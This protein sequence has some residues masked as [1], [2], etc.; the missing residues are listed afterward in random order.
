MCLFN[1]TMR[2]S[3]HNIIIDKTILFIPVGH[4]GVVSWAS[5]CHIHWALLQSMFGIILS[6]SAFTHCLCCHKFCSSDTWLQGLII[7][8]SCGLADWRRIYWVAL[9]CFV[10]TMWHWHLTSF[11]IQWEWHLVSMFLARTGYRAIVRHMNHWACIFLGF[12]GAGSYA[13]RILQWSLLLRYEVDSRCS[14]VKCE[15]S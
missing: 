4:I 14:G 9:S 8:N 2:Y 11:L 5:H 10:H 7:A 15:I 6:V 1:V 12:Y 13:R 3:W